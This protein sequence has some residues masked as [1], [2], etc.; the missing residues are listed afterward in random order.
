MHL[1]IQLVGT[2]PCAFPAALMQFWLH[3]LKQV[4]MPVIHPLPNP[5]WHLNPARD[6]K[7]SQ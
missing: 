3:P 7:L 5:W 1:F 6:K 4:R 2:I